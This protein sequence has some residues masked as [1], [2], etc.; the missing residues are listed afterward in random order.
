[1]DSW[2]KDAR[3][4]W[5]TY[6]EEFA[7]QWTRMQELSSLCVYFLF[8]KRLVDNKYSRNIE[9]IL[10]WFFF[11]FVVHIHASRKKNQ[12]Q[13][14]KLA[15][16]TKCLPSFYFII[17][18]FERDIF[19]VWNVFIIIVHQI[20]LFIITHASPGKKLYQQS[21][22]ALHYLQ[23]ELED[24]TQQIWKVFFSFRVSP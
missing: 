9:R 17:I 18:F 1:M 20:Y 3:G 22:E 14:S 16:I 11:R 10:K 7:K 15:W 13:R 12:V 6:L 5:D 19:F 21:K 2:G 8:C 24:F 4:V 23:H